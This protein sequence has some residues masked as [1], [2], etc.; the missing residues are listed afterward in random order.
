MK[1]RLLCFLI[2]VLCV[3][4]LA[5]TGCG[6]EEEMKEVG[7]KP[8]TL[9]LYGIT[10]ETTTE[11]AIKA[12]EE[13]LNVYTEGKF[14]THIVLKL[15]PEDE[16]YKIIDEKLADIDRIKKEE[17]E[18]AKKKKE[19][20]KLL[21]QMGQTRPPESTTVETE[22]E[23]YEEN[24][25]TKVVYPDV[26]ET[27]LDIFMVQG[28]ANLNKYKEAGYLNGLSDSINN[29]T[30]LIS[31]YIAPELLAAATI[32]GR[33]QQNG[34][35][36]KTG[37]VYGVPNNTVAGEY[38]YLLVNKELA[39][40]YYYS[41]NDVKT[42]D[43]LVNFLDDAATN[44]ADYITLYNEP[45]LA[46]AYL[47]E[48]PSLIGDLVTGSTYAFTR[49]TPGN[50]LS[51]SGYNNYVNSV[52]EL[53]KQNRIVD[54]D[55]YRLPE[56]QKIAAAFIKGNAALSAEYE[57]EYYVIE[58]AK[59]MAK[60]TEWPGTMFCV[61]SY[62][63]GTT[64]RCM[65]VIQALQTVSSFRN[66]FQYGVNGVHYSEDE[67]TGIVNILNDD[68]AMD[69]DDTGNLFLLKPNNR[70][71]ETELALAANNWELAKQQYRDTVIS[72][73]TMFNFKVV[74]AENYKTTSAV[75]A[76]MY[77]EALDAAKAEAKA[78]GEKFDASKFEFDA[79]YPHVYT[80]VIL[81]E[82]TKLSQEYMEQ[83]DN[84]EEYVDEEGNTVTM[85]DYLKILRAE[86]E[87]NEYY[88][89]L[90]D[91]TNPDSPLSQYTKWYTN[92]GPKLV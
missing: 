44:H 42:L 20:D 64:E 49:M 27:Q 8:L 14:N 59:P 80:D 82:L 37:V 33:G 16:Y 24:G 54:G 41:A 53:R 1:K 10:G 89:M 7:K 52:Y 79:E 36:D 47:T 6:D 67:Y 86:L 48:E 66:T 87:A 29:T 5:L 61:S 75:Y 26:K 39:K 56:D 11:E 19:E 51:M 81:S 71:S 21:Q 78:K 31:Q 90:V 40:Q 83:I 76:S 65:E 58:Y 74:T 34:L 62:T 45:P 55:A 18:A 57:D 15:Y 73:Y 28:T 85:K 2:A 9:T 77:Q 92:H 50:L 70:M 35:V 63:V 12:V 46:A 38:T 17:E 43:L 88:Q 32:G 4:P 22:A 23:T 84:F 72:P 30:K 91:D 13:E 69:P 25:A 60:P 68:Y 3:L